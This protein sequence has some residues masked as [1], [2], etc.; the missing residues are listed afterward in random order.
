MFLYLDCK[1]DWCFIGTLRCYCFSV[2]P[3][4]RLVCFLPAT[5][6]NFGD[7][8]LIYSHNKISSF[9]VLKRRPATPCIFSGL[10]GEY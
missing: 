8:R 3:N 1:S 6:I 4:H 7:T 2:E 10:V 5:E 9:L